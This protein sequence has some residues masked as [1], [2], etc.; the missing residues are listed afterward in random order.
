MGLNRYDRF[1][2]NP[3]VATLAGGFLIYL[4]FTRG[5]GFL[6]ILGLVVGLLWLVGSWANV[7]SKGRFLEWLFS[8]DDEEAEVGAEELESSH[9]NV[10]QNLAEAIQ[11]GLE[12]NGDLRT[13]IRLLDLDKVKSPQDARVLCSALQEI[14]R[15]GR[16][17]WRPLLQLL[18]RPGSPTVYE[19]FA[20]QGVPLIHEIL[21]Y[22]TE[23]GEAEDY[24]ETVLL[25]RPI[26]AYGYTPAFPDVA[27]MARDP[28]FSDSYFWDVAFHNANEDYEVAHVLHAELADP[29]PRTSPLSPISTGP[30]AGA[31]KITSTPIPSIATQEWSGWRPGWRTPI[32]K[33][34][35]RQ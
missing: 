19:I 18:L 1:N 10:P 27:S 12:P 7:L 6:T 3:L 23:H 15:E 30:T 20:Q 25:L 11:R 5:F 22:E 35:R 33:P 34:T 28:R 4:P 29:S 21:R 32:R 24:S 14:R 17:K 16:E 13:Q 26:I 9:E 2:Y 31:L 8:E